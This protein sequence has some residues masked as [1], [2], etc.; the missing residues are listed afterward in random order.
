MLAIQNTF[1]SGV[2]GFVFGV[3]IPAN[4]EFAPTVEIIVNKAFCNIAP[5]IS[6]FPF[7]FIT[8]ETACFN[9]S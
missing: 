3:A 9:C 2:P 7:V 8:S 4:V 6:W 5:I 1:W